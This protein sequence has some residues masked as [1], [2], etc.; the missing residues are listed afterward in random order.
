VTTAVGAGAS[1]LA[2]FAV[3]GSSLPI[4]GHFPVSPTGERQISLF[5]RFAED[6]ESYVS[7]CGSSVGRNGGL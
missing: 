6:T 5:L 4:N 2:F 7:H 3:F 1:L